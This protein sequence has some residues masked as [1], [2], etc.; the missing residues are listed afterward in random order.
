MS[1]LWK[2][3]GDGRFRTANQSRSPQR[4]T[5]ASDSR[6]DLSTSRSH[7]SGPTMAA[8]RSPRVTKIVFRL[9][10]PHFSIVGTQEMRIVIK[11]MN[12]NRFLV[13]KHLISLSFG[14]LGGINRVMIGG[15]LLNIGGSL[16][17]HH[18]IHHPIIE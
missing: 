8:R 9:C 17:K 2:S 14:S 6:V 18:P 11:L 13:P 12:C 10:I 4:M 3:Q 16:Y 7:S 15:S 5:G 1:S